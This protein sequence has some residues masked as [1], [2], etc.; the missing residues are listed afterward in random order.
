MGG[1]RQMLLLE[2]CEGKETRCWG[3]RICKERGRKSNKEDR[4]GNPGGGKG[5]GGSQGIKTKEDEGEG[6]GSSSPGRT[7]GLCFAP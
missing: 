3:W 4:R 1:G 6:R 2:G 5:G 7:G